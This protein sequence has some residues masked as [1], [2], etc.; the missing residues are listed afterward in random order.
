MQRAQAVLIDDD[1]FAGFNIANIFGFN[2]IQGAGFRSQHI[3]AVD[4]AQ[5]Q[6]TKTIGVAHTDQLVRVHMT[7]E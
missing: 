6:G 1:N 5:T 3:T 7:T 2:Q 4:P